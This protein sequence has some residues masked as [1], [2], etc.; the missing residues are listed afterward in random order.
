MPEYLAPG[1]YVEEIDTGSKPIE[2]VST[3]TAGMVGVTERGPLNVPILITSY[4]EFRRWFGDH[5]DATEFKNANGYHCYLPHAVEG[6]FT[7]GGQRVYVTRVLRDDAA[8]ATINLFD[9]GDAASVVSALLRTAG[10]GTGTLVNMPLVS[11]ITPGALTAGDW[12]RVGDGSQSEYREIVAA[13]PSTNIA[14]SFPL[15]FSHDAGATLHQLTRANDPAYAGNFTLTAAVAAGGRVVTVQA[16]TAADLTV[17]DASFATTMLEIGT[18]PQTE[19]RYVTA[20]SGTGT[21]RTI[22]LDS[23][24]V[25]AYPNGTVLQPTQV[26]AVLGTDPTV[27]A[28]ATAGDPVIFAT[29]LGGAF[30]DPTKLVAI[31]QGGSQPEVRRIGALQELA[32][33]EGAYAAY[34][35]DSQVE[36]FSAV[37]DDRMI[38]AVVAGVDTATLQA[39]YDTTGLAPGQQVV[40]DP[41][42]TPEA[43]VIRSLDATANT[44][45]FTTTLS[46]HAAGTVMA[47]KA[48]TLTAATVPGDVSI[49]LDNRLGLAVN[50]VICVGVAPNTE[51]ATIAAL[52]GTPGP[53]P[54]AGAVVLSAP[55]ALA[56]ASGEQVSRQIS[57]VASGAHQPMFTVVDTPIGSDMLFVSDDDAFAAGNLIRVKTPLG[58]TYFHTLAAAASAVTP[59]EFELNTPLD[60]SHEVGAP[61]VQRSALMQVQAIDPGTWGDRLRISVEDETNGLASGALLSAVN[62][63]SEIKLSSPTG[64]EAGTILELSGP[65]PTDPVVGPLLKVD[66]IN[67]TNGRIALATPLNGVQMAAF[68]AASGA[69][70]SLRVRSRE[71]RVAV[72]LMRRPDPAV[73]SR[74]DTVTD[75]ELFTSLSMDPRHSRYFAT[76]IGD[77]NGPLRLSDRR[78]E[79]SS[80]Y[81]R[82]SDVATT[83]GEQES[84][85]LGPETLIDVLPS[86]RIRPARHALLNGD[87]SLTMLA[88]DVYAGQDAVDPED[89]TGLQS[90]KN[91][92]D[93]SIVAIPGRTSTELQGA[94]ISHCEDMRY[95]FAVLDAQR[96]PDDAIAD[97]MAQRQQFD[98]K[99]AALYHP[100]LLVP[101]PYPTTATPS[102]NYQIPP[103]GHMVGVYAR[104]DIERGVHKA[105]AN[106]VVNGIVGLQRSLNKGE[107]DILNPYPVNINVIRDFRVNSRGIR[108][109]GARVITSDTDW[110]YVNVRRLLIYIEH[111]IDRG[112]QSFV[113]EPN[114]EPLWARVKRTVSNFLTTVWR[115]GALEGT[116]AEEAFFVKCDRTTMTQDDIDNGRLICVIGVAPVKPAEYVIIRIGLW[117]AQADGQ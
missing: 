103:S 94:V 95:R 105:P 64:V 97:V 109:W 43:K 67:R 32:L 50:D 22:T 11:V 63:P 35:R 114:A 53:A 28:A 23:A 41:A 51:Y 85:R 117:T 81:V 69:G 111:S 98:T 19:Y 12:I 49:S 2:G 58:A 20:V 112:V 14:L 21:S 56:H 107:Q 84:I 65:A 25:Q 1:V 3:S 54:D 82:M 57:S 101:E 34:P 10:Q 17:L 79:G 26:T 71:F 29:D 108:S 89:R 62:N 77:I 91:I 90:L 80:W 47:L 100:W 30:N 86:G 74:D 24:L 110:K 55:L 46:A 31:D 27:L 102:M 38:A 75:S 13:H 45:R 4:G 40:L 59:Q 48:K 6:F 9:R 16:G 33:E 37:N 8:S 60:R 15:S 36:Q 78:P 42:G 39:P 106:E 116:K 104:T 115:N 93:V 7:N 87:D 99:Y 61:V 83:E 52:T 18:F 44:V 70:K 72:M 66:S 76:V 113:F 5:L 96:S 68:V 92:D 73:P 88:D